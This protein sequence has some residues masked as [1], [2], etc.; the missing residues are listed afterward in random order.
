M[1]Q[2][3]PQPS[4]LSRL[5]NATPQDLPS[6]L[7]HITDPLTAPFATLPPLSELPIE[8]GGPH[9]SWHHNRQALLE[10]HLQQARQLPANDVL[11]TGGLLGQPQPGSHYPAAPSMSR[12]KVGAFKPPVSL[13]V[14]LPSTRSAV[15]WLPC[16]PLFELIAACVVLVVTRAAVAWLRCCPL[17]Q[18]PSFSCS[19][20][21]P[22][23]ASCV[24]D[25]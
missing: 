25:L 7:R 2:D 13:P 9:S 15:A 21:K 4:L 19:Q 14:S 5:L 10:H 11:P 8:P 23:H 16:W 3:S 17:F 1:A 6:M 12:S 20:I 18:L 24:A 22:Y